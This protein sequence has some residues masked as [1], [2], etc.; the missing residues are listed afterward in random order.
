[1]G[2]LKL[3][4][5]KICVSW[6]WEELMTKFVWMPRRLEC[7]F[8]PGSDQICQ[9]ECLQPKLFPQLCTTFR[10]WHGQWP[11]FKET[12]KMWKWVWQKATFGTWVSFDQKVFEEEI[13][14]TEKWL[15]RTLSGTIP[16]CS[17]D[18]LCATRFSPI[19]V[20]TRIV[21]NR[22]CCRRN[23]LEDSKKYTC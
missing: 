2:Q 22:T 17:L 12:R 18:W 7:L 10:R 16:S 9:F 1:M 19:S 15:L 4:P 14:R 3:S 6:S 11:P 13:V 20:A 23:K 5:L 8:W 21:Q